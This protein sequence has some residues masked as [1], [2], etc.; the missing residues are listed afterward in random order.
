MELKHPNVGY[1]VD[2]FILSLLYDIVTSMKGHN[3]ERCQECLFSITEDKDREWGF[4]FYLLV[5]ECFGRW[6]KELYPFNKTHQ[7][8]VYWTKF[9]KIKQQLPY[10]PFAFYIDSPFK[11]LSFKDILFLNWKRKEEL[12]EGYT[13]SRSN[14][15][16]SYDD[17]NCKLIRIYSLGPKKKE[18][19]DMM[20]FLEVQHVQFEE[21]RILNIKE[22]LD[23]YGLN[24]D[25][26]D[27]TASFGD[28]EKD[29]KK[30]TQVNLNL[31]SSS[32]IKSK[33]INKELTMSRVQSEPALGNKKKAFNQE[34]NSLIIRYKKLRNARESLVGE[35]RLTYNN[36][37]RI[38]F[39]KA[40]FSTIMEENYID[41]REFCQYA[42]NEYLSIKRQIN[43]EIRFA[44]LFL[45]YYDKHFEGKESD[46]EEL[47][48]LKIMT[49]KLYKKT[50]DFKEGKGDSPKSKIGKIPEL[51]K[52][53]KSFH[54]FTKLKNKK[55]KEL[56]T[57]SSKLK[58]KKAVPFKVN[59]NL[60]S[61]AVQQMLPK[62]RKTL[63]NNLVY[64]YQTL[65]LKNKLLKEKEKGL[66][67]AIL[68]LQQEGS[69][70]KSLK[71]QENTSIN[72]SSLNHLSLS[73]TRDRT[74][75]INN[76][77]ISTLID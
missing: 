38:R 71:K 52:L 64:K 24:E 8:S 76:K 20:E 55:R 27:K 13:N 47:S 17:G 5:C 73:Q 12:K 60:Q 45:Q 23:E 56:E 72:S 49:Y 74:R 1:I 33:P 61:K 28:I 65:S 21:E 37:K 11:D 42:G 14:S 70:I 7:Q 39:K 59:N 30:R 57:A 62:R 6:G 41:F 35:I 3:W 53:K 19:E 77:T 66:R 2:R 36:V 31:N 63:K 43:L 18:D 32:A 69:K 54:L 68:K 15:T 9:Q 22:K 29:S 34:V 51:K 75:E 46:S 25:E 40:V 16:E 48:K 4:R 10:C 44:N 26:G 58:T 50:D 67:K